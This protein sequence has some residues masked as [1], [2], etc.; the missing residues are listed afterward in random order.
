MNSNLNKYAPMVGTRLVSAHKT[1]TIQS[2]AK[3]SLEF[4]FGTCFFK[5]RFDFL[6]FFFLNAFFQR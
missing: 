4:G 2:S 3:E 6:G 5:L 1:D